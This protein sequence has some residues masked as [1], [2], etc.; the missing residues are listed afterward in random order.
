M[1][2]I[3]KIRDK[4]A[5]LAG[6]VI[7]LAL[8]GFILTDLG[9]G[10]G[11]FFSNTT[12]VG[13][14]NGDKIDYTEYELALAKRREMVQQQNNGQ[15]LSEEQDAQ[16]RDEVWNEMIAERLLADVQEKLGISVSKAEMMDMFTGPTPD[17]LVVQNLRNP[18]TGQFDPQQAAAI[19]QQY[20]RTTDPQQKAQW[21]AFKEQLSVQRLQRKFSNMISGAIYTPKA[22]LDAQHID[23]NTYA[24]INYVHLPYSLIADDQVKVTDDDVRK[25]MEE[26]RSLFEQKEKSRSAEI[27]MFEVVP[28]AADTQTMLSLLDTLKSQFIHTSD[29]TSF[30]NLNSDNPFPPS[31]HT[32]KTLDGLPNKEEIIAATPGS[33]VGPFLQGN[34]YWLAKISDKRSAPDSVK[35]RHILVMTTDRQ[36]QQLLTDEAAKA[37]MDSIVAYEKGGVPFDTLVARFS[38]DQG[39]RDQGGVIDWTLDRKA[40]LAPEFADFMFSGAVGEKKVVKTVFGYHYIQVMTKSAP[41]TESKIAFLVKRFQPSDLT[42]QELSTRANTF[43]VNAAKGGNAFEKEALAAGVT[44]QPVAGINPNSQVIPNIGASRDMVKWAYEA[45]EGEVSPIFLINGNYAVAKL[46]G[47]MEPGLPKVTAQIRSMLE[48]EIKRRKKA[49]MLLD[50]TKGKANLEAIATAEGQTVAKADSVTFYS[51]GNSVLGN[52]PKVLGYTFNKSLKENTV[53]PGIPGNMGVY[54]ISVASRLNNAENVQRDANREQQM[55]NFMMRNNATSMVIN[56]IKESAEVEDTRAKVY[57][58]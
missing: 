28:S 44:P 53:S 15:Q 40:Q 17:P 46:T 48:P 13:K 19:F 24:S 58:R 6:G 8:I 29:D 37:R 4:Y 1:A 20:E 25:F 22:I 10:G 5:K 47:I 33:I 56:A 55:A 45:K 34:N 49:Q 11:N 43:A 39:S 21:A 51:G 18:E 52:E 41:V 16:L 54:Y 27:V 9:K 57:N 32:V 7:V 26:N 2:I 30:V 23:R 3:Q 35:A 36:G 38:D 42:N 50:K 31:Y 14:I 12:T